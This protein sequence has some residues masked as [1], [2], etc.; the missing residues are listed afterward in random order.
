MI[1]G[2][3]IDVVEIARFEQALTRTPGLAGRLFTDRERTLP[4][5]SL[6]ARFA[7]KEAL[8][9]ALGGPRGL[10]WTDAEVVANDRG[11]PSLMVYGTV[12]AAAARLGVARWHLSLSHDAGIASAVVIAEGDRA[13]G[14]G[15]V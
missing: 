8:A 4:P 15:W 7:A 10:L 14:L 13:A 1:A 6:A 12:A 2:V 9:K 11:R 3:G 5:H